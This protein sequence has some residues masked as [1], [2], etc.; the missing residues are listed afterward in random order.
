MH[1]LKNTS[2]E[3]VHGRFAGTSPTATATRLKVHNVFPKVTFPPWL[4]LVKIC[5]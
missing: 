2:K 5:F 1:A 4:H 3:H